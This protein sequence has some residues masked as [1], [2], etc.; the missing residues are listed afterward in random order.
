VAS[1]RPAVRSAAAAIALAAL[2]AGCSGSGTHDPYVKPGKRVAAPSL[3]GTD[4]QG[5]AVSLAT[6]RGRVSVVNFWAS[7]CAPCR[8]ESAD[9]EAVARAQPAVAFVGVNEDHTNKAAAISFAR[10]RGL[11]Y[12]SVFDPDDKIVG[13]WNVP[14][15]PQTFIVDATGRIAARF[16]GAVTKDELT[17]MLARVQGA[18]AVTPAASA[19][20]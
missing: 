16:L 10:S 14:D 17:T 5:S 2:V 4:L 7:W 18:A 15:L 12:P 13:A 11:S 20:G 8:A 3:Q 9:L 1:R 6:G 19:A